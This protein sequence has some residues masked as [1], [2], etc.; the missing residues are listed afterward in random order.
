[1]S[2]VHC[3]RVG[4]GE[5]LI[6]IHGWGV[7]LTIWHP[8]I[9]R[10]SQH[11]RLH[12]IDLPGFGK[13]KM[14]TP[15]TFD[16]LVATILKVVPNQAIWCGWSLG[17]L[18]A[19]HAAYLH[20]EKVIKLI[21]VCSPIKFIHDH[22]WHGI[23]NHV[24]DRFTIEIEQNTIKTLTRFINL[25][26]LGSCSAKKDV[27]FI[28]KQVFNKN[29]ATKNALIAGLLLLNKAD[30]RLEFSAISQPCLSIFGRFDNLVPAQISEAMKQLLPH[31]QQLIFDRS[32]HIP[33]ITEP[34]NFCDALITFSLR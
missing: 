5:D 4:Q 32:S 15:Y 20:P 25:Q 21:Q 12:L 19:T 34:D 13:S 24:F 28:K 2:I 30:L 8:I 18:L 29:V 7:N 10:L 31:S 14:I 3:E 17:G 11:F 26:A 22:D 33:F 6:L 1:M 23:K 9:K 27:L 16:A